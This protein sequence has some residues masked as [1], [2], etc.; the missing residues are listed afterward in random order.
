MQFYCCCWP[1]KYF[2]KGLKLK[3]FNIFFLPGQFIKRPHWSQQWAKTCKNGSKMA[4]QFN[5]D[6]FLLMKFGLKVSLLVKKKVPKLAKLQ[7]D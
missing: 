2:I 1:S 5:L 7:S 3:C 4:F 6:I